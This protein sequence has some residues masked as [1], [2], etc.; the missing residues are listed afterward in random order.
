MTVMVV[1]AM[2]A[3]VL[4]ISM[5]KMCTAIFANK[6]I[7]N[8]SGLFLLVKFLWLG[9]ASER[10]MAPIESPFRYLCVYSCIVPVSVYVC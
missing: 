8:L 1:A 2:V 6:A 9:G 3:M 10:L 5:L 4:Y 7:E